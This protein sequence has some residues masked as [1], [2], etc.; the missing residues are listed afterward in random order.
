MPEESHI[1][2][3]PVKAY[4]ERWMCLKE[5]CEGEMVSANTCG[6]TSPPRYI[7]ICVACGREGLSTKTYPRIAFR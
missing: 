7:H 4:K 3:T 1:S 5:S 2:R 6:V